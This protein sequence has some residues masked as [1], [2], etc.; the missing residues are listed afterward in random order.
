MNDADPMVDLMPGETLLQSWHISARSF[1]VRLGVIL[2]IWVIV[3]QL[4]GYGKSLPVLLLAIPGAAL[5]GLF[6]MWVFGEL[7]IWARNRDTEWHL[8]D[9]AIL[10]VPGDE[11]PAR[12]PLAEIRRINRWP[13]WSLVIRFNSG[14]ATTVP[15][16][17]RPGELRR[18]ILEARAHVLPEGAV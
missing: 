15:I 3:G 8:T 9:R 7:D 16:P 5:V 13:I 14:T 17:P 4:G 12:L 11:L 6:Y 18:R 2:G 10:V 1:L